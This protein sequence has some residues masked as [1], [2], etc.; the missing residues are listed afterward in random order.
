M[1]TIKLNGKDQTLPD[2][3]VVNDLFLIL[4]AE[5]KNVAVVVNETI[6]RPENRSSHRLQDGDQVEILAFAGG[7]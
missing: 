7:G 1:I 6:V 2:A 3:S 5:G 4:G